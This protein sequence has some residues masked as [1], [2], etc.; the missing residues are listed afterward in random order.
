[1]R[2]IL[3]TQIFFPSFVFARNLSAS[4]RYSP[5][6]VPKLLR[7][8]KLIIPISMGRYSLGEK[9]KIEYDEM[10]SSLFIYTENLLREGAVKSVDILSTAGLQRINW[11]DAQVEEVEAH[12]FQRHER[13]LSSQ[14][15][16]YRWDEWINKQGKVR[17]EK[18]YQEIT[19]KS[20]KGTEWY[21]LM[22][23]THENTKMSVDLERSLE[24]QRREYAAIV[25]MDNYT[26]LAYAGYIS[27]AWSY[28]YHVMHD[29]ITLPVFTRVN[30]EKKS[31][32]E[33]LIS[34]ADAS[35]TTKIILNMIE[36]TLTS[37]SFPNEEKIKLTDTSMSLFYAYTPKRAKI[38]PL[39]LDLPDQKGSSLK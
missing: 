38:E 4:V 16:F 18:C 6:F 33:S 11:N 12:F 21:N 10:L 34:I 36:Q 25:L 26:H 9:K 3:K 24:Y 39:Q 23:K 14:S 13:L 32:P 17:F 27:L 29:D 1:M 7:D 37:P 5:V 20:A 30:F 22:V 19:K 2:Q 8:S 28:L 35:H 15:N 31:K